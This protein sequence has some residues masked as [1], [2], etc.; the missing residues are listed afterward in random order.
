MAPSAAIVF[1]AISRWCQR[2]NV[3]GVTIVATSA[4]S[5]RPSPLA[6]A[7]KRRPL[8]IRESQ[9]VVRPAVRE[10]H[11]SPGASIR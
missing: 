4:K 8:V 3:S 6:L 1:W 5:F 7:A 11:G 2:N 9:N 10:E